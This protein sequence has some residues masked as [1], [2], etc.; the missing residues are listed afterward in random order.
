[1]KK[2]LSNSNLPS[3]EQRQNTLYSIYDVDDFYEVLERERARADRSNQRLSLLVF[4][5]GLPDIEG[6]IVRH[7]VSVLVSRLRISDEIGWFDRQCIGIILPYTSAE[8]AW[9]L[10]EEVCQ[11]FNGNGRALSSFCSVYT[12]PFEKQS[13]DSNSEKFILTRV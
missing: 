5:L 2:T 6:D 11:G 10:A 1:M 3:Q 12:Y 9:K 13:S 8:G 4:E 7:L